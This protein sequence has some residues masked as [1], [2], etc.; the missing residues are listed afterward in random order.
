MDKGSIMIDTVPL[1][2]KPLRFDI[3][4]DLI[5]EFEVDARIIIRH[6]WVIGIPV[7]LLMLDRIRKNKRNYRA[8]LRK[9][10]LMLV[11]K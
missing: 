8:L 5:S 2:E 7:P 9:F 3:P 6:P 1:P 10:D 11:P 4:I